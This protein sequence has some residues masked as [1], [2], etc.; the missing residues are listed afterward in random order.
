MSGAGANVVEV[1]V[2]EQPSFTFNVLPLLP[3]PFIPNG[4]GFVRGYDI[5]PDG[6]RFIGLVPAGQAKPELRASRPLR[7]S[8][9]SSTG[10][11]T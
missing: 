11:R 10:S 3:R 9:S 7:K 6:K 1:S 8:R 4:S 2:A 5:H